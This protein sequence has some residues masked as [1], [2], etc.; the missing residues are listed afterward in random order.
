MSRYFKNNKEELLK[1]GFTY[2]FGNEAKA[3]ATI[4]GIFVAIGE[5]LGGAA[6]GIFGK[7]TVKGGR[8]PIVILG[9]CVSM[10]A[11]FLAF[12]NLPNESTFKETSAQQLAFI[13]T[14]LHQFINII[15][16][17]K[18]GWPKY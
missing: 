13:G 4:S 14:A 2:A 16:D 7:L 9:F 15:I 11:Y 6:F 18:H 17:L 12:I 1:T 3:L 8:D 5:V 10:L